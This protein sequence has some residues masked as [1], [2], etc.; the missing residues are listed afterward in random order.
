MVEEEKPQQHLL[1]VLEGITARKYLMRFA[2]NSNIMAVISSVQ[3]SEG[4]AI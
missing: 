4:A 3:H 1:S 2:V